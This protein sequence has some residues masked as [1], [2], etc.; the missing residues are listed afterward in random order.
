[1]N[2]KQT[3]ELVK[4]SRRRPNQVAAVNYNIRFYPLSVEVRTRI[5]RGD[6]GDVFYVRGSYTQDWLLYP[7]DFNWRVIASEGGA[8]RAVGDVGTHW[9]DLVRYLTGLDIVEVFADLRTVHPIRRRPLGEVQTYKDK[10]AGKAGK[11]RRKPIRITTEDYGT[12][13]LKFR[14]GARG[15]L[16]VSQV[17]AGAKNR[18]EYEIGCAKGSFRWVSELPNEVWMGSRENPNSVL[19][20][21][22]SLMTR[23]AAKFANFPGGHN[24][25]F[26]DTFK[27]NFKAIY[28][29]VAVGRMSKDSLYAKFEDGHEEVV[30]CDAILESNRK[31]R[32]VRVR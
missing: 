31:K 22:P 24:E 25:G 28:A 3:A 14:S 9:L 11:I 30:L 19:L 2:A 4:E 5:R 1:M 27:Q 8:T 15:A 7:D 6:F 26:P 23:E 12:V 29:D 17:T 18:L 20:R 10:E 21:D 16:T 13:I 32:W